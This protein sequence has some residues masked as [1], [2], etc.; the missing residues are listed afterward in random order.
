M[1]ER[2]KKKGNKKCKRSLKC[3]NKFQKEFVVKKNQQIQLINYNVQSVEWSANKALKTSK[4][5]V[6]ETVQFTA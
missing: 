6:S 2:E 4:S 1:R 5:N 3:N